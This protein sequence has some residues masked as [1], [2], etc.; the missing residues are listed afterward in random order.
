M[1]T[2]RSGVRLVVALPA[3]DEAET[4]QD[5]IES[6]P[7]AIEGVAHVD[8]LVVDD[9]CTDQTA[10]LARQAGARVV[11]HGVNRGVGA[12]I[13]TALAQASRW[14]ADVL[15]N[16]DAD[17]QFDPSYIETLVQPILEG[18]ADMVTASRFKDPELVPDMPG[19]KLWGNR[20]MSRLVSFIVGQRYHDVSCGFRAYSTE[21][22]RRLVLTGSF[23]YTQESFLVLATKGLKIE[24]IPVPVRG[25]REHGKSR[26]ASNLWRYAWRTSSI[27]FGSLRDY[28]PSLFFNTTALLL[29]L[30]ALGVGGFFIYHRITAGQFTPHIWAGF[31]SAFVA[32]LATLVF[33]LGQI[34]GMLSTLRGIQDEQ[35][36]LLRRL[37]ASV[38]ER[39]TD[40]PSR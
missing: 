23:T 12:A 21:A 11:S 31:V 3:L 20:Q 5:V 32:G 8:V 24:E 28:Q 18:R 34:A 25:T 7:R 1:T 26:V 29:L 2:N 10:E 33:S 38:D 16:M 40:G 22:M 14:G 39:S 19:V 15:V 37:E 6:I 17:G 13:Q 35:L 4:I 27:I 36:Y 9:G 30:V